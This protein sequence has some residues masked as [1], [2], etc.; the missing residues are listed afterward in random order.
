MP[1]LHIKTFLTM[2]H[3]IGLTIGLGGATILVS[4]MLRLG[5]Q[6]RAIQQ[7]DANLVA[8]VSKLVTWALV[9][10]WVSGIGFEIQYWYVSPDIMANPK[11]YAKL[12]IVVILTVNGM[13]LH[14][15]VLP[16]VYRRVGQP[17]FDGLTSRELNTMLVCGTISMF[18][19]YTPFFLGIARE[20][21]FV[22]P[23]TAILAV[24]AA[25]VAAAIAIGLSLAPTVVRFVARR[26]AAAS[27]ASLWRASSV[28]RTPAIGEPRGPQAHP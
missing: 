10:L 26:R 18:S 9:A 17:L 1:L 3:L 19:W 28:G 12:A 2:G 11:V 23:A 25:M 8:L 16:I 21:N 14:S 27:P 20:M 5:V 4:I 13:V 24:Y 15:R 7:N 6:G 22:V